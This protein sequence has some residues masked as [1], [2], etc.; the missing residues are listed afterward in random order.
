M[1]VRDRTEKKSPHI[2]KRM[3]FE[4][5]DLIEGQPVYMRY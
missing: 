1:A 5:F 3:G 4:F 2:L